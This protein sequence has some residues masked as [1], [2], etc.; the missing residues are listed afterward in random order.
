M[1][2]IT[3]LGLWGA[4]EREYL[5]EHGS[6]MLLSHET[7][8]GDKGSRITAQMLIDGGH[9]TVHGEGNGPIAAFVHGLARE[10]GFGFDVLDYS[11][12][13][14]SAGTDATAVAYVEVQHENGQVRWGVGRDESILNAS[15]KGVVSAVNRL[16]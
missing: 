12:H 2:E 1:T 16:R 4:F 7:T 14:V 15:L 9:R 3:P 8:T 13:A 5:P 11:E 10:L 6:I